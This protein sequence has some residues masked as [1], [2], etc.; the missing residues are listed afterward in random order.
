MSVPNSNILFKKKWFNSLL[1]KGPAQPL[2]HINSF[3]N[4]SLNKLLQKYDYKKISS[5]VLVKSIIKKKDFSTRT[6][7]TAVRI[8]FNN[9]YSTSILFKK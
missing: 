9:F 7:K 2:E 3:T 5:I 8:I 1:I 6:V 4:N